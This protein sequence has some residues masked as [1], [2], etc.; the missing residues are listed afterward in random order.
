M[1]EAGV[2]RKI[3]SGQPL[4]DLQ[5]VGKEVLGPAERLTILREIDL[6]IAQGDSVAIVGASG[7]GK[8]TLLHILGAL[9]APSWGA[10]QYRGHDM[11]SL[12]EMRR[13]QL[14]NMEMGFIFQF[15]HLLP[16]FTTVE[17]VAMP[18]IIAGQ[19]RQQAMAAAYESLERVGMADRA[20]HHVTTLSG[21]ERQ[22]AAIARAIIMGPRVLLADEP[23]GSL[24]EANGRRIADL[25]L[26]LNKT[27][28]MTLVAV[29][30]NSELA[31]AMSRRYELHSGVLH[32][33]D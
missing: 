19:N 2:P 8:T 31:E 3:T 5:G 27:L 10:V 1:A 29:T 13:S 21:G 20:A 23:S 15:H 18:A 30:H 26:E 22:R 33:L 11:A 9:D 12:D 4:F 7:S 28:G 25:M 6:T 17:N 14:R 32:A 16:E 24:D